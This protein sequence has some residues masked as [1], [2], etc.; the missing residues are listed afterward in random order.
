MSR[1]T[2]EQDLVPLSALDPAD[3]MAL[4]AREMN[5]KY[6]ETRRLGRFGRALLSVD[7]SAGGTPWHR[8]PGRP[9]S[10]GC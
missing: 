10:H 4:T 7:G 3:A 2:V 5:A 6:K 9:S 1:D 8:G